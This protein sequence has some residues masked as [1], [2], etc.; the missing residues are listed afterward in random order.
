MC[1]IELLLCQLTCLRIVACFVFVF[2]LILVVTDILSC[3]GD[4]QILIVLMM[5]SVHPAGM[6]IDVLLLPALVG[7]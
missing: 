3:K 6:L 7:A 4:W 5:N 2:F 1:V